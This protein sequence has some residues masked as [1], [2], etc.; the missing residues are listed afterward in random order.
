MDDDL[1][2]GLV[3]AGFVMVVAVLGGLIGH[4][5]FNGEKDNSVVDEKTKEERKMGGSEMMVVKDSSGNKMLVNLANV[6]YVIPDGKFTVLF[7]A[8]GKRVAV[9]GSFRE[10]AEM[11]ME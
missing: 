2:G 10:V 8:S 9:E 3:F 6:D 1:F 11:I 7:F 4:Y 5:S